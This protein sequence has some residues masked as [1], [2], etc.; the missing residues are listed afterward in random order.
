MF[1]FLGANTQLL[2]GKIGNRL[3]AT[4]INEYP[5][6]EVMAE[7][8]FLPE[9]H[10]EDAAK[11]CR[12]L[13]RFNTVN[14][15]GEEQVAS[16]Y[17]LE[18][19]KPY[20]FEGELLV[21][22]DK[23]ATGIARLRGTG[24]L[25]AVMFNGHVDVVPV[26]ME[27]WRYDP[28]AG[29]IAEGKVWGRGASDMKGG[30]A[31]M[32]VAAQAVA[33]SG[34]KLR[35][36]LIVSATGGEE[37]NMLGARE[38]AKYP[39][40]GPLQAVIISEPTSNNIA[41]AERGVLWPEITTRGKTAHGST[42]HLGKNAVQMMLALIRELEKMEIP[43]EP[44]PTLG[45]FTRSL[46]IFRGGT[47]P[48]VIPDSCV[49]VYDYRTVPGQD[50]GQLLAQI[51]EKIAVLAQT[52]PDFQ[53][54]V[55]AVNDLPPAETLPDD[56]A[57]RKFQASASAAAGRQV[58]IVVMRFAT[59]ACIFVPQLGVPCIVLGP[60][61]PALAHQPNEFVEIEAMGEAARM[62]TR[63]ALDMLG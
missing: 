59:E 23:R 9:I 31:A 36:D 56:P 20:G 54:S 60:G 47:Q 48:N 35:G 51:E 46:D 49:A 18:A 7:T 17:V 27:P 53:A 3:I 12:D 30:L 41:L 6:G 16:E 29:E 33:K 37:V 19:L 40:L 11:V 43:F 52:Y 8:G 57:V 5:K 45:N 44:H 14:P 24:E 50:H 34:Q 22:A 38:L 13:I 39:G 62:Y 4:I 10:P 58:E 61:D 25:P 28:F 21:H 1:F 63:A 42:P 2:R 15:P 26:G 55:K 32:I